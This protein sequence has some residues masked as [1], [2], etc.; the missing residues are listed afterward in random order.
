MPAATPAPA[1]AAQRYDAVRQLSLLLAQPLSPEDCQAQSMPCCS[2]VKWH[3]AH[4]TWF[5]ETF[6]VQRADP[7]RPP[8]D[9]RLRQLFH[10]YEVGDSKLPPASHGLLTRPSLAEVLD[11]RA[12]VDATMHALL[13]RPGGLGDQAGA[14][15]DL[16]LQ[17]EQQHQERQLAD[18][19]HLLSCN[20]LR[21]AYAQAPAPGAL[22]AGTPAG[23]THYAGGQVRLGHEGAGFA[24]SNEHP[25]HGVLLPP[26]YLADRLVTQGEYLEFMLD[27]GYRR[28]EIWLSLGWEAVQSAGW[29]APLYWEGQ[30]DAWQVYTLHGMQ[31][32]DPH[33]PVVH[34]SYF[35]A[36]AYAR[37]AR[38]RLPREAEWEHA[39]RLRK[40]GNGDRPNLL[41]NGLLQPRP[42]PV[43]MLARNGHGPVQLLGDAWEWT[44][45]AYDAYPGHQPPAGMQGEYNGKFMCNQYVLR[46]GSCITPGSLI[47]T[48]YRHFLPPG[49]RWQFTGIRL[50]RNA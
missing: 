26:Y 42:A 24:F 22:P 44:S 29:K 28:P 20:P 45:S 19:K 33:A 1:S 27:G 4:T 10:A 50:A 7:G 23:W 41:E 13:S 48:T 39:A 11:Y 18:I 30:K 49:A 12:H 34:V 32:L 47:R 5:F 35:E 25:A 21:P 37:W 40:E 36:D 2:P 6:V 9:P 43:P 15:F 8:Y 17:H 3:L 38:V 16:A 31:A 14:F 46:G